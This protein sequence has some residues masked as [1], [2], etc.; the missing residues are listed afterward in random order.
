VAHV[1]TDLSDEILALL[2]SMPGGLEFEAVIA[3]IGADGRVSPRA[4]RNLL[5]ELADKGQIHRQR[6]RT[7]VRGAPRLVFYHPRYV[8][9]QMMLTDLVPDLKDLQVADRTSLEAEELEQD[10]RDAQ[11]R[12]QS[13]L[14]QL[15]RRHVGEEHLAQA[16]IDVAPR[17]AEE[18]PIDLILDMAQWVVDDINA[19][20]EQIKRLRST[21]LGAAEQLAGEMQVRIKWAQRVLQRFFRLDRGAE[22]LPGI[23]NVPKSAKHYLGGER[24]T[25]DRDAALR[26]LGDRIVGTRVIDMVPLGPCPH[27]DVVGTDA[28]VADVYLE[29]ARGSFVPPDPISVITAAATLQRRSSDGR[30]TYQ[31]FDVFPDKLREYRDTAAAENG[32][33]ISP[34]FREILP[35]QDFKHSRMAAMDLR[36]YAEDLRIGLKEAHWRPMGSAPLLEKPPRPTMIIRD[37][38]I[39]PLVHRM[40]DFEDDGLYG[41]IVRGEIAKYASAVHN[42]LEGPSGRI[43][44]AATVK[45]PELSWF[46]PL[47]MW[48]LHSRTIDVGGRTLGAQDV[49]LSSLADTA[50]PHLLFLG[51][52]KSCGVALESHAFRTFVMLRRFSDIAVG[53]DGLLPIVRRGDGSDSVHEDER[54]DWELFVRQR[55][56]ERRQSYV[57]GRDEGADLDDDEY[58]AFIS[59]CAGAA[60]AMAYMAPAGAYRHLVADDQGAHFLLPRFEFAVRTGAKDTERRA[61]QDAHDLLAWMAE[62]GMELDGYHTQD[63]FDPAH[64]GGLPI[65]V[66]DVIVGAHE[67]ATFARSVLGEDFTDAVKELVAELRRRSARS[68]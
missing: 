5:N 23:L 65:L 35:E 26:R 1:A 7:S 52:A 18:R 24:A 6:R 60:V 32:L 36:Q 14:Y 51:L 39:F 4:V 54:E 2:E 44:Y 42:L 11:L 30:A 55:R 61:L 64:E 62:G 21:N 43:T 29:H 37:G 13:V 12:S 66:P 38:R 25:L 56:E 48:Y 46:A 50:V 31:E 47:T 49:Y 28:S 8:A 20:G 40:R 17:L 59:L 9:L 57:A 19:L 67:T 63:A 41:R 22:G 16:I 34:L 10:E 45:S 68:Y 58:A 33:V 27:T 53:D 3:H 15:A